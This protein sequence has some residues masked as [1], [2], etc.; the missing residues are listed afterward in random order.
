M[1]KRVVVTGLGAVSPLGN[2]V[3]STWDGIV[4]GRS[5]VAPV[6]KF[7]ASGYR[8]RIAAEAR[9]FDPSAHFEAKDLRRMDPV[10]QFALVAAR[11]AVADAGIAFDDELKQ[12]AAVII[13]SGIGGM[14]KVA[15]LRGSAPFSSP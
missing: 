2:D 1:R 6:T 13:G 3:N 10:V 7:D 4:N 12:R 8:A 11:E 5:G 9:G 14:D 15:G